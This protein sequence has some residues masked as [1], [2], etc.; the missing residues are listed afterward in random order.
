MTTEARPGIPFLAATRG[1]RGEA[2]FQRTCDVF[3]IR[4]GGDLVEANHIACD[5]KASPLMRVWTLTCTGLAVPFEMTYGPAGQDLKLYTSGHSFEDQ[6]R[7]AGSSLKRGVRGEV[8][9][10]LAHS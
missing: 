7:Q 9:R 10:I 6:V 5:R 3:Q 2:S 1:P 8:E 4:S